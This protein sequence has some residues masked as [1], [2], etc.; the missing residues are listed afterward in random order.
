MKHLREFIE[1]VEAVKKYNDDAEDQK[2]TA[3]L[4]I[5]DYLKRQNKMQLYHKYV[6]TLS[7][8]HKNLRNYIESGLC[9]LLIADDLDWDDAT[10]L[11]DSDPPITYG[12]HKE[13]LYKQAIQSI[14]EQ[15]KD[16]ERCFPI[17]DRLLKR[18]QFETREYKKLAELMRQQAK[19]FDN[20][21]DTSRV[22]S[23]YFYVGFFGN[24]FKNRNLKNQEYIYRGTGK[25]TILEFNKRMKSY[26]PEAQIISETEPP[27][28]QIR[29]SDA[30]YIQT[31]MVNCAPD[32]SYNDQ[33]DYIR[34]YSESNCI[35][36]FMFSRSY[37][38]SAEKTDNDFKDMYTTKSYYEVPEVFPT[39]HRK[40]LVVRT[41]KVELSPIENAC[42]NMEE[43]VN[44]F[45]R[46]V[47]LNNPKSLSLAL[48]GTIEAAVNGGVY[49][50]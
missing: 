6:N 5:M 47:K 46:L 10:L 31:Y 34:T 23:Y 45:T 22:Y 30:E 12:K 17:I 37:R 13:N 19:F 42:E 2:T 33:P 16:Y 15:G 14:G 50:I 24:G 7:I 36:A 25:E 8:M 40:Q 3:C 39:T 21:V 4:K 41:W 35:K 26:F 11:Q 29:E 1:L 20:I 32:K 27:S 28:E 48:T 49:N 18:Y 38:A 9:M 43:N 44:K